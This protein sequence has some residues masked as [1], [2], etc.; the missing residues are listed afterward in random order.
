MDESDG[1]RAV[2]RYRLGLRLANVL[3]GLGAGMVVAGAFYFAT[4]GAILGLADVAMGGA[5]MAAAALY[6]R[7]GQRLLVEQTTRNL[8]ASV[9]EPE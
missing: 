7:K 2:R 8:L 9:S 4:N 5:A 6:D 1:A 3:C